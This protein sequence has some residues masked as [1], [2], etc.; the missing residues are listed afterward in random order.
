MASA[1]SPRRP[2]SVTLSCDRSRGHNFWCRAM[3][4]GFLVENGNFLAVSTLGPILP[5]FVDFMA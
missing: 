3:K 2:A 1:V 5:K 4:F